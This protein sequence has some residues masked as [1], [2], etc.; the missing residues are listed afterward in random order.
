TKVMTLASLLFCL[1]AFNQPAA[2]QG[3]VAWIPQFVD[4]FDGQSVWQTTLLVDR[5]VF[6][7]TQGIVRVFDPRGTFLHQFGFGFGFGFGSFLGFNVFGQPIFAGPFTPLRFFN[8]RELLGRPL[9]TGFLL[10]ETPGTVNI[11]ALIRRFSISGTLMSEFRISPLDPFHRARLLSEEFEARLLAFALINTD[12]FRATFGRF[13]F[14]PLGSLDPIFSFPFEIAP[15]GQFARFLSE[16]FPEVAASGLRG[17]IRITS[18]Q[19]LSA[20]VL[21]INGDQIRQVE[22]VIEN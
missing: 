18:D 8:F 20:L 4:G 21:E 10:I 14:F 11:V 6:T 22:L 5:P 15:H 2:A 3:G 17:T 13:E 19:A 9:R 12:R 16:M 1:L 7:T